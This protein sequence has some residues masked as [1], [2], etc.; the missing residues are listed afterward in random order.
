M[1]PG[2]RTIFCKEREDGLGILEEG[3]DQVGLGN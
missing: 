2:C 1:K 3:S